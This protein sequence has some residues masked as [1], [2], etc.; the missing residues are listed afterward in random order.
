[1]S[2]RFVRRA[3]AVLFVS[4]FVAGAMAQ[5]FPSKNV[6]IMVPYPAGGA[7]DYVARQLQAEYQKQLGQAVVIENL[8]GVSGALGVQKVL[9]APADGYNQVLATPME[10]VLAPLALSA[11]KFKPEDVRLAAM[12]GSTSVTMLIRKDIPANTIDEFLVWAKGKEPSYGSVG[13]G[14]LYHL[15]GEKFSSLTGQKMLHVPYKGGA[16][17]MTDLAGGQ[18]DMAFFPLAGP[19]PGMIADKRVKVIA[20]AAP[21]P[22][23]L[24]PDLPIMSSHRLLPDFNF[25]LW[26]GVQVP[27]ATPDA[28]VVRINQAMSDTLKNPELRKNLMST[29]SAV[30][31]PMSVAELDKLYVTEVARYR[32]LFK[33]INL[34]PQ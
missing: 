25:D 29:G 33:S 27:K 1:M 16:Q 22:H 8:G 23:V 4:G 26:I 13:P 7:S 30:P 14:S 17:L 21:Q 20:I 24:F 18:V 6:N 28:T 10:L 9:A 32:A 5:G 34:Q 19:V 2:L 12:I 15:M 31:P 3:A 11:V